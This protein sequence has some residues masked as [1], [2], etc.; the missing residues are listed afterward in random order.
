MT[1]RFEKI[2][3]I[4]DIHC[5]HLHLERAL[6]WLT[7]RGV[8]VIV[9]TGDIADGVGSLDRCC[10]L[11]SSHAVMAVAGNHD[12]WLLSESARQLS[13]ATALDSIS[14]ATRGYIARLPRLAELETPQGTLLLCHGLG[15]NDMAKVTPDDSDYSVAANTDLQN[16]IRE[17]YYRWVIN[18]HSHRRMV[19]SFGGTTI[20]NAGT[21]KS[22]DSPCFL[23]IDFLRGA[24]SVFELTPDGVTSGELLPLR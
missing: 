23:E 21:I 6:A 5:E 22:D 1:R 24:V 4:G 16:L 13:N 2:G 19:R 17:R 8:D 9:A 20:I 7:T 10:E 11:L 15:P 14:E 18:G 12:R 3:A